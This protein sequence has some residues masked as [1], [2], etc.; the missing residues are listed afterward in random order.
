MRV[1]ADGREFHLTYCQNVH[2]GEDADAVF[3][4]VDRRFAGVVAALAARGHVGPKA[5]GL[6]IGSR[7]AREFAEDGFL[8]ERLGARLLE[9]DAYAIS[10]N[11][12]PFGDF[13]ADRIKREVYRPDWSRRE[14]LDYTV[15]VSRILAELPG[16][17]RSLSIS[18]LPLTF[19]AFG[20]A[21][22]EA[23]AAGIAAAAAE[24]SLCS[25]GCERPLVLGIEPEPGGWIETVDEAV[26]FFE[27]H[28]LA[29]RWKALEA[30]KPGNRALQEAILRQHVGICFDT[31]HAAVEYEPM[32]EALG[33]LEAAGIAVAK[34]QL[35]NA[36]Q[37]DEPGR[38]EPALAELA[39]F[40]ENR[41]LHQVIARR[42]DG[43]LDYFEDLPD[44]LAVAR[45]RD[46]ESARAHFHVP[47]HRR[48]M[49]TL[50]TTQADLD[51]AIAW[52]RRRPTTE[53]LEI[54]TYTWPCLPGRREADIDA[55][56]SGDIADE[57]EYVL[58]RLES[59]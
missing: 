30:L 12:F 51:Q 20:T 52:C 21:D 37:I 41:Y 47:L 5:A 55:D 17:S 35:S 15:E 34:M 24:L 26:R 57:Y 56:L 13:H 25:A 23:L 54:E 28:L 4:T 27:D 48:R 8:V 10:V 38:N 50:A 46:D 39:G 14:R 29:G 3:E 2:P 11:A 42:R 32:R 43:G 40:V 1:R 33:R 36:L 59:R 53:H 9:L 31:C 45:S 22:V 49:G 16:A 44:Y 58:A 6:R 7:A 18:T 19:K